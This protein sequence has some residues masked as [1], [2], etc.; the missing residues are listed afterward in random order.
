MFH[1]MIL[2]QSMYNFE[3]K[4]FQLFITKRK[5]NP[6]GKIAEKDRVEECIFGYCILNAKQQINENSLLQSYFLLFL[7]AGTHTFRTT[8][9]KRN[10]Q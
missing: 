1:F 4:P 9:N 8:H 7:P 2:S 6:I 5:S 3:T 10:K